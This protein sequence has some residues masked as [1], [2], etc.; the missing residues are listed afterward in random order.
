MNA[1]MFAAFGA[2]FAAIL[3]PQAAIAA[4]C[5]TE[6]YAEAKRECALAGRGNDDDCDNTY[7]KSLGGGQ[8][9]LFDCIIKWHLKPGMNFDFLD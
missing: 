6:F 4:E 5:K 2:L 1:K 3:I 9:D 8:S 7:Y